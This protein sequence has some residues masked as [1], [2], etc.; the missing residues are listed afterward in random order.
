M[1]LALVAVVAESFKDWSVRK[2]SEP[3]VPEK[4]H[5]QVIGSDGPEDAVVALATVRA[6]TAKQDALIDCVAEMQGQVQS[7]ESDMRKTY[8]QVHDA[9]KGLPADKPKE[10]KPKIACPECLYQ[11]ASGCLCALPCKDGSRFTLAKEEKMFD[12]RTDYKSKIYKVSKEPAP[13]PEDEKS[14]GV[15]VDLKPVDPSRVKG[16]LSCAMG[17]FFCRRSTRSGRDAGRR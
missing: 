9:I 15:L 8:K 3:R 17:S 6:V 11:G 7:V 13:T 16:F 1:G 10:E 14:E 5:G 2:M 12:P 4:W